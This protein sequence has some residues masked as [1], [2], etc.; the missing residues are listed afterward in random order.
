MSGVGAGAKSEMKR[1]NGAVSEVKR[2]KD[3]QMRFVRDRS[4]V[5][6]PDLRFVGVVG[7]NMFGGGE[8]AEFSRP[9]DAALRR[10]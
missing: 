6:A 7:A 4:G 9:E 3:S 8:E 10:E 2:S 5:G 1:G